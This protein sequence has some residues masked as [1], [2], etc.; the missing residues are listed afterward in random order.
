M[1]LLQP[2]TWKLLLLMW[3]L[4]TDI[5]AGQQSVQI[6]EGPLYRVKGFP[7]SIY[8]S[9]SGLTTFRTQDFAFSIYHP[10]KREP[11]QIIS[12][13]D[14]NFAYAIYSKRVREGNIEIKRLSDT[15]V[16]FHIKSLSENDSGRYEC[17]TPNTDGRFFGTYSAETTVNVIEDTLVVSYSGPASH[18]ISVGESLQLECQISS[19]TFQHTHLSV[20]WYLRGSNDTRPI[21]SLDRYLTIKPAPEFEH[22]YRSGHITMEKIEDTT[23][24]LKITQIQQSDS[25]ELYCQA[26][27]WVQDPDRSWFRICHKTSKGSNIEVKALDTPQKEGSFVTQIQVLNEA[28]EEGD[29]MEIQCSIEAQKLPGNFFAMTWLRNNMIV[30]QFDYNGVQTIADTY[31]KREKDG[32]LRTVRKRDK[33][34]V[35]TIQPVRVE[36]QGT[37]QCNAENVETETGSFIRG[38]KQLSNEAHV[39]IRTKE[40]GLAVVMTRQLVNVTEGETLQISCSISGAKGLLSVSWQ[41]KKST[42][43]S[44]SDVIT[45]SREGVMGAVGPQYQH[46]GLRT[47]RSNVADFILELNGALPSDSG[48]YMCIVSEWN[49]ESN[50][51]LKK[52]NS[53]S[54]QGW[55]SVK[56]IDSLAKVVLKT[57]TVHVTENSPIKMFCSVKAPKVSLAV[58]WKFEPQNS[59]S[60]KD[61]ICIDHIGSMSCGAE[62]QEYQ[63]ETQVQESGTDYILKVLRASNQQV[64]KYQCQIDA[65]DKNIQKTRKLSNP[66]A[67]TVRRP[68]SQL[69]VSTNLKSPLKIQANSN[70]EI[71]C[72]VTSATFNSSRFEVTWKHGTESLL[73]MGPEGVITQEIDERISMKRTDR[74]TFQLM[75]RQVK[76]TDSGHYHCSV[77]EWIQ[78]PNGNWYN[79]DTKSVTIKIDVFEKEGDFNM[80]KTNA[81]LEVTEGEQVKLNCSLKPSGLEQTFRYSLSWFFQSQDQSTVK[82]LTYSHDGRLQFQVTDS[83]VQ[84]RLYFSRPIINVFYLS[85]V[86]S[87]PSDS[88]SYYCEVDQYQSDCK[89]KWERKASNR[90]GVTNVMVHFIANKLQV[91]KSRRSLNVTDIQTG[92][93]VECKITSRSSEKSV[94]EVT[95]SRRQ[96]DERPLTI[97]TTSRDGTLRSAIPDRTLVYDR[98]STTLYTLTVPN[99]D[100]SDNGQYQCQVVEWLQTAANTWRKVAEDKSGELFIN[101]AGEL[102]STEG[103][104]TLH[105]FATQQNATEGEQMDISCSITVDQVDTKFHY[106]FTWFVERQDSSA[107]TFLLSHTHTGLLQYQSENQQLR[108]RLLFSRP[109]AKRSQL[110]ILNLDPSDSGIYQCRVEQYQLNCEGNWEKRGFPK[111]ISSIVNVHKIESKLQVHKSRRFLNVTDIQTGFIVECKITSRSS[112]K[113]VFEV[114]WSRRQKDEQ[115]FSIFTASRDGTLHS[116]IPDRNLVYDR[117]ST[118]LYTL[119]IPNVDSS[120]NGQYHCQVIEWLQTDATTWRKVSEDKSGELSVNVEELLYEQPCSS[121]VTLGILIPLLCVLLVV[122]ILLLIKFKKMKSTLKKEKKCLWAESMP[123]STVTETAAGTKVQ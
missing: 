123:L 3:L 75:M 112:K 93:M 18:S 14:R 120:D 92:F 55:V 48:E 16:T 115:L 118:T 82:L 122:V 85:I 76:P 31:I 45:L 109:T 68:A 27:E 7:M 86:N 57:R 96:K 119:T 83:D 97:F 84:H 54:Q 78:D 98:P 47:F 88:G 87:I 71:N 26:D 17:Y 63:M 12:T 90:S 73:R 91:H 114:T 110:S 56:S 11:I 80:D 1:V 37:Y 21:I 72:L 38:K 103:D 15:S 13:N 2:Q 108:G 101:V 5:C 19:H 43:N 89:G 32:E 111:L 62:Q 10:T 117:P 39:H 51:N 41:H 40:S 46:R 99:V 20:T 25:G 94:F 8:C 4:Q 66:L 44:F 60:Q 95:W 42:S 29:T 70:T 22:R 102:R 105:T 9:V 49:M 113:S 30:A 64:G 61:I 81:Q 67:I 23:Y 77:Q 106:S 53:Q 65:Y 116:M 79:L 33:N 28:L 74:K 59:T 24:R 107:S 52:V 58:T 50:G 36:D 34:F 35:L 100:F 69:S 104:F 121:G 6:Q